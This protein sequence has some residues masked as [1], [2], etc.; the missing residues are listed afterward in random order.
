MENGDSLHWAHAHRN[1]GLDTPNYNNLTFLLHARANLLLLIENIRYT[2][3]KRTYPLFS[4]QNH[5]DARSA[6][7]F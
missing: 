7:H 3:L 4:Q 2:L 5:D 1:A 6:R